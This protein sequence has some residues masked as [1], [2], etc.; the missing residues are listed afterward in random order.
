MSNRVSRLFVGIGSAALLWVLLWYQFAFPVKAAE[1]IRETINFQGKVVNS[2]GTNVTNGSYDFVFSIYNVASAGSATWTETW[3]VGTSQVTVTDGVF[4]VELGTHSN[5]SSFDFNADT[6]YLGV[7]FNGD[8][9]MD[10]RIRLTAVPYAF[11]AKTVSGL[12]VQDSAG[13]AD[14]TGIL[15]VADGST[16]TFVADFST[17]GANALTLT[18]TGTTNVTL[19]TTGT[20]AT[21][22]GSETLTNKTIG[23]TGLSFENA[24]SITNGTDGTLIF[25]T[26]ETDGAGVVRFPV[27]TTTGDPVLNVE[28]NMYYNTFDNK[29]RCYQNAGWTDCIGAGGT[30]AWDTIGDPSGN[31]SVAMA[32]TVQTLDWNTAVTA[33]GFTGLSM[34]MTNDAVVDITSQS[35]LELNNANDGGATGT[36]ESI[37]VINNADTNEA[38]ETGIKFVNAGGGF[39]TGIDMANLIIA[40]VGASG[41]DFSG[42]GGL[43]LA[44]ALSVTSGGIA[45]TAGGATITSGSLAVNSDSVTSDGVLTIDANDSVVLGGGGNTYTFDESSGPL[46]AGTARPAR[47]Q[48]LSPEYPGATLTADGGSNSGTMTTDFCEQGASADVPDTNTSVCNTSGDIHNYYSWTT[49]QG[50]AQDYDIWVRWRVPDNFAAWD[51]N[52]IQVYA[53][54]TDATN[55]AVSVYVYDTAGVLENAGGTQVAGTTWTQTA[56]EASFAGTY[57]PGS[58]LTVRLVLTADTGGDSVQVG[59]M[60]L[61]YLS[62]N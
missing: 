49:S 31:G 25:A 30:T 32:E 57:T 4:Q 21:L 36:T 1:G 13:G 40:N 55:N 62:N 17:S 10:P 54:R 11:N 38:V 18:T 14:T 7:N 2:N 60:N 59:E 8:G 56:V 34:T 39:T 50:S 29:F 5:L 33:A 28:G 52:P 37:L 58:Y 3:N 22:A 61:N 47:K 15:K 26:D 23:N 51:S 53:K 48:T 19:P 6:W 12:T 42:T 43:T 16:L 9:E 35:L 24:E 44:D 45:V 41:T 27:K 46:Y 20:L